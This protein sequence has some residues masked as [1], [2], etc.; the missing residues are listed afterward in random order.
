MA[1]QKVYRN[2]TKSYP[3]Q[4][5]PSEWFG[6]KTPKRKAIPSEGDVMPFV[7]TDMQLR[8]YER[9]G[10]LSNYIEHWL[11]RNVV[12]VMQETHEHHHDIMRET[13]SIL[14]GHTNTKCPHISSF[15]QQY[16][17][18]CAWL[19]VRVTAEN[20]TSVTSWNAWHIL[21]PT[22]LWTE[23]IQYEQ[24]QNSNKPWSSS[25]YIR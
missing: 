20:R 2:I 12:T 6:M 9:H 11:H 13:S 21:F 25:V 3:K 18:R 8:H 22:D 19:C 4:I 7:C 24:T 14:R 10:T 23:T 17:L 5:L 1:A 16:S 15:S